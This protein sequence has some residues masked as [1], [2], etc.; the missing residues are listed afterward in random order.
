MKN[1]DFCELFVALFVALSV[2]ILL[3]VFLHFSRKYSL[4]ANKIGIIF[5]W[6]VSALENKELRVI[7]EYIEK[8]NKCTNRRT[9]IDGRT[10]IFSTGRLYLSV[11]WLISTRLHVMKTSACF[12]KPWWNISPVYIDEIFTSVIVILFLDYF[13]L[14]CEMKSHHGLI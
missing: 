13:H 9:D 3:E 10:V 12:F 4:R 11:T 5:T 8:C 1:T 6:I 2:Y 14:L 7:L